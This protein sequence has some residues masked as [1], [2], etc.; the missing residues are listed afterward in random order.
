MIYTTENNMEFIIQKGFMI[1]NKNNRF[2]KFELIAFN[3]TDITVNNKE[4]VRVSFI[5]NEKDSSS[6][7][8]FNEINKNFG[9]Y[10]DKTEYVFYIEYFDYMFDYNFVS[11]FDIFK[12]EYIKG[13][14]NTTEYKKEDLPE[15]WCPF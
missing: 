10:Q 13:L 15:N 6:N 2:N 14:S 8:F 7:N 1:F 5:V 3:D 9:R 12:E 11:L 4:M